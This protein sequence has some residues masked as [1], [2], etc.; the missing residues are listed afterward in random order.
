MLSI[1][2]P[3]YNYTCVN[4]V[5]QLI[6][7]ANYA[8]KKTYPSFEYEIL[9]GDDGSTDINCLHANRNINQYSHCRY[10]EYGINRGRAII[11]NELANAANFN[12][13]LF[14]DCDASLIDNLYIQRYIN[15]IAQ[16]PVICGSLRTPVFPLPTQKRL[17]YLY[18]IRAERMRTLIYRKKHP[19]DFFSTFNFA[20]Q[21]NLFLS[22]R[23]DERCQHYGYEDTLFGLKLKQNQ[24][25]ILHI[26]NPLLHLGIED[27]QTFLCKTETALKT[28]YRLGPEIQQYA[29]ISNMTHRLSLWKCKGLIKL[30]HKLFGRLERNHLNRFGAP[31]IILNLYKLG[32]YCTLNDSTN[33]RIV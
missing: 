1:L 29:K 14:I 5:Q 2:I 20:I 30:W 12:F 22:I 31:L 32:F 18:E 19:Y 9:V 6:T 23:F 7:S 16:A 4:L 33:E 15:A 17:R 21:K 3:T 25:A 28:L 27:N 10:I 24:I 26:E 13:L 11:R 8:Q